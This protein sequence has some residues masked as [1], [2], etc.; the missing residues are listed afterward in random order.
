MKR[1]LSFVLMALLFFT[2]LTAC[3]RIDNKNNI[4]ENNTSESDGKQYKVSFKNLNNYVCQISN[5]SSIGITKK[6]TSQKTSKNMA[7][8][9]LGSNVITLS[10]KKLNAEKSNETEDTNVLVITTD[11][12]DPNDPKFD[13]SGLTSVTFKRIITE[14]ITT[15]TIGSF[16][17][18]PE[19]K[20]DIY[21][22]DFELMSGFSYQ[23][24]D[25][26]NKLVFDDFKDN[27]IIDLNEEVGFGRVEC[28]Y[29]SKYTIKYTGVGQEEIITQDEIDGVVDKFI[30]LGNYSFISF[31]PRGKSNRP[32]NIDLLEQDCFGVIDY[33]RTDYYSSNDRQ[34]YVIDNNSGYIYK[35]DGVSISKIHNNLLFIN[36]L[37][38]DY[39]IT[40]NSNLRF[41]PLL[42]NTT[43]EINDYMKDCY[44]NNYIFNDKISMLDESTNTKYVIF[45]GIKN[46]FLTSKNEIV[47]LVFSNMTLKKLD[48]NR[49]LI[50]FTKEEN[51]TI[52]FKEID[53]DYENWCL[54][55]IENGYAYFYCLEAVAH[56]STRFRLYD[57]VNNK[58]YERNIGL[59]NT[60]SGGWNKNCINATYI[61]DNH[62]I[63]YTDLVDGVGEL[64]TAEVW[65]DPETANKSEWYSAYVSTNCMEPGTEE[66]LN[67]ILSSSGNLKPTL[68]LD[69]CV[70]ESWNN[71]YYSSW[72]LSVSTLTSAE[73]YI[74]VVEDGN[75]KVVNEN[76]YVAPPSQD[77]ILYPINR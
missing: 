4:D 74:V 49:N 70:E 69:N 50:D 61:D 41:F 12:Y 64:Y 68:L 75:V 25:V 22:I 54:S 3:N 43:I 31:V 52:N 13:E 42:T 2:T 34:S 45:D 14:N 59:Y 55:R 62:M 7:K 38:Y 57:I 29:P 27:S 63:F 35:I 11:D 47:Y 1:I 33:D 19:L 28:E 73:Y 72:R 18:Y 9:S 56:G 51:Y 40:D 58:S 37:V 10:A 5:A 53:C 6:Q 65:G 17:I 30:I 66:S 26:N 67:R 39:E 76:N 20:N 77:Y 15:T 48:K 8:K 36:N 23:I 60:T 44:G 16:D 21:V 71:A 46:Y 24:Y 32:N